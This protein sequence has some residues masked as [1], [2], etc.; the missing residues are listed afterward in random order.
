VP[1][2]LAPRSEASASS[3]VP[4]RKASASSEVPL[5]ETPK[6]QGD[7]FVVLPRAGGREKRVLG[8][9]EQNVHGRESSKRQQRGFGQQRGA[10]QRDGDVAR[11]DFA[12]RKRTKNLS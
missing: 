6:P 4:L 1:L 3:K 7:D 5:S 10:A 9:N 2:N 12:V 11:G 8:W